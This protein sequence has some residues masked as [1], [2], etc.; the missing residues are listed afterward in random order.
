M[1]LKPR[2]WAEQLSDW[3]PLKIRNERCLD[4]GAK[5]DLTPCSF[6]HND[7][8]LLTI[9]AQIQQ[10]VATISKS[11]NTFLSNIHYQMST[12]FTASIQCLKTTNSSKF[13][14]GQPQTVRR[15]CS[16]LLSRECIL[17]L[18]LTEDSEGSCNNIH[19]TT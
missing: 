16:A 15:T 11:I 7:P 1:K 4:C 5:S 6:L 9:I 10:N 14:M 12:V 19:R 3:I 13:F 2:L 18:K 17:L 8:L